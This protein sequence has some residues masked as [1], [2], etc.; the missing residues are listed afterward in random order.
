MRYAFAP[1]LLTFGQ[2]RHV[3]TTRRCGQLR[4]AHLGDAALFWAGHSVNEELARMLPVLL[5]HFAA[6]CESWCRN[7]LISDRVFRDALPADVHVLP[8]ELSFCS[9]S[10][11]AGLV[12]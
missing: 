4:L 1:F 11:S 7:V 2:E 9:D 8:L 3:L 10:L 12:V 6:V 5:V